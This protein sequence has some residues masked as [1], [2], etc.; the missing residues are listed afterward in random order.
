MFPYLLSSS[1]NFQFI[2]DEKG[3]QGS[4]LVFDGEQ[5]L[6][7][8]EDCDLSPGDSMKKNLEAT[9]FFLDPTL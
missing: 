9:P 1:S 6:D 2:K 3:I 7:T 5:R 8:K 4:D